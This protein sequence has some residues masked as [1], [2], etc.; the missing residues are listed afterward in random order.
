MNSN[1]KPLVS[2]Q[3]VLALGV[4]L[5][6]QKQQFWVKFLAV[7]DHISNCT[8]LEISYLL[9]LLGVRFQRTIVNRLERGQKFIGPIGCCVEI[10]GQ[11]R[12]WDQGPDLLFALTQSRLLIGL[13]R[14]HVPA[15]GRGPMERA[16]RRIPAS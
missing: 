8:H 4:M 15:H 14:L 16:E 7:F 3:I 1:L 5:F 12:E 6:Q 10:L 11:K 9:H 2:K 13:A